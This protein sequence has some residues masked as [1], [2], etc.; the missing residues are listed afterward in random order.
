M[1]CAHSIGK[2]W[3]EASPFHRLH[4][5]GR[6]LE[7]SCHLEFVY[8][9]LGCTEKEH[10]CWFVLWCVLR[11][12]KE[13]RGR[14]KAMWLKHEHFKG[15]YGSLVIFSKELFKGHCVFLEL[16]FCVV[17]LPFL[18]QHVLIVPADCILFGCHSVL[19]ILETEVVGNSIHISGTRQQSHNKGGDNLHSK[20]AFGLERMGCPHGGV[21]A[22]IWEIMEGRLIALSLL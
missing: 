4:L 18:R 21:M 12:G 1:G 15:V 10:T 5:H 3:C 2:R 7:L 9:F 14:Q 13:E 11:N 22:F 19:G 17:D 16:Y 8:C 6:F 20:W